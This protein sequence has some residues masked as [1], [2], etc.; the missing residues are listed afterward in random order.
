MW[1]GETMQ[2]LTGTR[3]G[4]RFAT[5][6]T[7]GAILALAITVS[8]AGP[9]AA[10]DPEISVDTTWLEDGESATV[11]L[12]DT[13]GVGF[14]FITV[15]GNADE[16]GSALPASDEFEFA[17]CHGLSQLGAGLHPVGTP[18]GPLTAS[19]VAYT[20]HSPI[21]NDERTC[22]TGGA[23]PCRVLVR[24]YSEG[25]T[26]ELATYRQDLPGPPIEAMVAGPAVPAD[27]T[28]LQFSV[29]GFGYRTGLA[30]ITQCAN[31]DAAGVPLPASAEFDV[32]GRCIALS[33]GIAVISPGDGVHVGGVAILAG[34]ASPSTVTSGTI[35]WQDP[36]PGNSGN[37][38]RCVPN[39]NFPC[40]VL[41]GDSGESLYVPLGESPF[42]TLVPGSA[43]VPEGD[44]GSSLIS[45]P[46]TLS[47]PVDWDVTTEWTIVPIDPEGGFGDPIGPGSFAIPAGET[48]G[49][50]G[51]LVLGDTLDEYDEQFWIRF[52]GTTGA[53]L[54]GFFGLGYGAI[55][56]D[57]DPPRVIP[58]FSEVG[59][60]AGN[61]AIGFELS[62]PSGKTVVV[63]WET[64][65]VSATAGVD[66][67]ATA[68]Q[69][70]FEPGDDFVTDFVPL[71]DDDEAEP[72][73]TFAV[74]TFNHVNAVPGGF[75]GFALHTILDDDRD[76]LP[77]LAPDADLRFCD[78]SG[79]TISSVD[80]SGADLRGST[81]NDA[82]LIDV[83]LSG[84]DLRSGLESTDFAGTQFVRVDLTG[85]DARGSWLGD[86]IFLHSTLDDFSAEAALL[87]RSI[88]IG[89]S[90]D[91]IDF[92]SAELGDATIIDGSMD[93]ADLT[94]AR[95]TSI[96]LLPGSFERPALTG[97][98]WGPDAVCP[99][100]TVSGDHANTCWRVPVEF[101]PVDYVAPV[102]LGHPTF[103]AAIAPSHGAPVSAFINTAVFGPGESPS[104]S[105][106]I[107]DPGG[108]GTDDRL[109]V[110]PTES[111][112]LLVGTTPYCILTSVPFSNVYGCADLRVTDTGLPPIS[113][114]ASPPAS[115][116]TSGPISGVGNA[117]G[118][119]VP[120]LSGPVGL[121][122]TASGVGFIFLIGSNRAS[123]SLGGET[124]KDDDDESN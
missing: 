46:V 101:L 27:G 17:N 119:L 60:S 72:N 33:G 87:P 65:A 55:I 38:L 61:A 43:T 67:V 58:H 95:A 20:M 51:L 42:P 62:E 71:I 110:F 103:Q 108:D 70:T 75:Y 40:A 7:L 115:P 12:D 53:E 99:D 41:F 56:D 25:G 44:T 5:A 109:Y 54:G 31:A 120:L 107:G 73:E 124:R 79:Q 91:G 89:S 105:T 24:V 69:V 8:S 36:M 1:A 52:H 114:P 85:A 22:I 11:T 76:C 78:F 28:L 64:I 30:T 98:H 50:I 49:S 113:P 35:S 97:T 117:P 15:C 80:I 118:G 39:G 6:V 121:M 21:G 23:F 13:E 34:G 102:D 92:S 2:I 4:P 84:T 122:L 116:P 94:R 81:F 77:L 68:G 111:A 45:I 66:F 9:A 96:T 93:D 88:F 19:S 37:D 100:G 10:D 3:G 83:D 16:N 14:W 29:S 106:G 59:E 32:F 123:V 63:N 86:A 82:T 48:S 18:G 57:D 104:L 112:Q 90:L 47:E 26:A 74:R